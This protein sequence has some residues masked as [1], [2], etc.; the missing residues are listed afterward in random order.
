MSWTIL[1]VF[2]KITGSTNATLQWNCLT[3]VPNNPKWWSGAGIN[4]PSTNRGL[5]STDA[6]NHNETSCSKS[7]QTFNTAQLIQTQRLHRV[8]LA[9]LMGHIH[10]S[11][12]LENMDWAPL[13]FMQGP[14]EVKKLITAF[15]FKELNHGID[16]YYLYQ[17]MQV[18]SATESREE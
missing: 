6:A 15:A 1:F 12:Y 11:V 10:S 13:W 18:L 2:N 16:K 14:G 5:Q 9:Q 4:W 3:Q 8:G 17:A 7:S